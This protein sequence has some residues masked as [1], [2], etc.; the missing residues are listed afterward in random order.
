[1]KRSGIIEIETF[2]IDFSGD[3]YGDDLQVELLRYLREEKMFASIDELI[4][5]MQRDL[6]RARALI[7]E[8]S[9]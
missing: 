9:A 5:A 2:L 4:D 8:E 6:I 1:V 3:I 7:A